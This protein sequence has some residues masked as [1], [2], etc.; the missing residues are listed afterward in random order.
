MT[1]NDIMKVASRAYC[2]EEPDLF[3]GYWDFDMEKPRLNMTGKVI[4]EPEDGRNDGLVR[5]LVVEIMET[6]EE[7]IDPRDQVEQV[8]AALDRASE[9]VSACS[10]AILS[11]AYDPHDGVLHKA[12]LEGGCGGTV[13]FTTK[14]ITI[15]QTS[16]GTHE[17]T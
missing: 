7:D 5:F 10:A 3:D 13:D 1:L 9:Q 11:Y 8:M 2:P 12:R 17:E 16:S 6:Y 15:G 14:T 4:G